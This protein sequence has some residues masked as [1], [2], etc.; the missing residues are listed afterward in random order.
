MKIW[1]SLGLVALVLTGCQNNE[2]EVKTF[3]M[4]VS[5]VVFPV[6]V[7][8][9]ESLTL[10][11]KLGSNCSEPVLKEFKVER[12]A[13]TLSLLAQR[14]VIVSKELP[15]ICPPVYFY[16]IKTYIDPGTPA[17]SNPFEVFVNGKSYGMITVNP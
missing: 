4:D 16:A 10:K 5:G 3:N 13:N 7:G 9:T 11:V 14:T 1:P 12:T 15:L 8:S 2:T 17:R 6:S